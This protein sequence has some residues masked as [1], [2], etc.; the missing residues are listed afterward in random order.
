MVILLRISISCEK[1]NNSLVNKKC[2]TIQKKCPC[3]VGSRG[4]DPRVWVPNLSKGF[5]SSSIYHLLGDPSPSSCDSFS[6]NRMSNSSVGMFYLGGWTLWIVWRVSSFVMGPQWCCLS[7]NTAEDVDHILWRRRFSS[8][9]WDNLFQRFGV[10][11]ARSKDGRSMVEQ[12]LLFPSFKNK[13]QILCILV[14]TSFMGLVVRE[15]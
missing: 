14:L 13:G 10:C 2:R 9:V 12:A 5:S 8:S 11:L 1:K 15:E 7:R 6:P 4:R 3:F